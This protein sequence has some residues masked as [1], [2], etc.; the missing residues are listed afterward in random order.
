[1]E[2]NEFPYWVT[3]AHLQGVT[4]RRKND[5]IVRLFEEGKTLID[6]FHNGPENWRNCYN[7][8][9][10]EIQIFSQGIDEIPNNSFLV[11]DLLEQGYAIVPITSKEYSRMLKKNLG[12]LAPTVIYTKGNRKIMQEDSI[13]IVGSRSANEISLQFT[14]NIAKKSAHEGKVIVSGFA[15]GVDKQ[16]L[17]SALNYNGRS[18]IVLPQGIMTFSSG[19]KNYYKQIVSGEVLV[20]STF[21]P[22]SPWKRELA[23]ARNTVIYGLAKEIYVAESSD[24]GGTWSGVMDGLRRNRIIHVRYPESG[25]KNANS[26][27]IDRGALA[28]DLEG[29]V[30]NDDINPDHVHVKKSTEFIRENI[31]NGTISFENKIREIIGNKALSLGDINKSLDMGWSMDKLRNRLKKLDFLEVDKK[32]KKN[33]YRIKSEKIDTQKLLFD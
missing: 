19:F 8:S 30:I 5:I 2:V 32:N 13:A 29:F 25:E 24:K 12:R 21:Y 22:R 23:M 17:D 11:E 4:T 33:L 18:I 9:D 10:K 3:L 6:F 1:M 7:L 15:K 28:V 27:L 16:A 31:C 14:D 26:L 20:I